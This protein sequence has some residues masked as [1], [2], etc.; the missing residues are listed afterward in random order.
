[1][2]FYSVLDENVNDRTR[3]AA[4]RGIAQFKLAISETDHL[5]TVYQAVASNSQENEKDYQYNYI[6]HNNPNIQKKNTP[7]RYTPKKVN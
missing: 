2:A 5:K 6:S 7:P 3:L 4:E 1:M